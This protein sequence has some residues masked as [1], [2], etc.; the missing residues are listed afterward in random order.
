MAYKQNGSAEDAS[1]EPKQE[2]PGQPMDTDNSQQN[3]ELPSVLEALQAVSQRDVNGVL[4]NPPEGA[5]V[6]TLR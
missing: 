5:T 6:V 3:I 4:N 1:T 2:E